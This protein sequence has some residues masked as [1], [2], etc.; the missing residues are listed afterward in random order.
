MLKQRLFTLG[1]SVCGGAALA[2]VAILLT[3]VV[4][5]VRVPLSV[6]AGAVGVAV[7]GAVAN[8]ADE[9]TIR[10][11]QGEL[12]PVLALFAP[13][14]VVLVSTL[15]VHAT[16]PAASVFWPAM[17]GVFLTL[18]G[19][20][21]MAHA[22]EKLHVE[23]LEAET[24]H[25]VRLPGRYTNL[26]R[27]YRP[28]I[29]VGAFAVVPVFGYAIWLLP[30]RLTWVYLL[31]APL[32]VSYKFVRNPDQVVVHEGIVNGVSV[33]PWDNFEGFE[34]TDDQL[35]LHFGGWGRNRLRFPLDEIDDVY[36]VT[37]ALSE[38]LRPAEKAY[39]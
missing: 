4:G 33:T 26:R 20:V 11:F 12:R 10:Q 28:W 22:A 8:R 14:A 31:L 37:Y 21:A 34:L 9:A 2:T 23:R 30:E 19:T 1:G 32:V 38:Y 24:P 16:M 13:S 18:G 5:T 3:G 27:R 7:G 17:A 29:V 35:V 25:S 6:A 39:V 15:A 36:T